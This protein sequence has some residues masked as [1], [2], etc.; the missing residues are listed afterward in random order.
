MDHLIPDYGLLLASGVLFVAYM[1]RGMVG[2]GSGLI[3]I[4]V[5][6]LAMPLTVAVPLVVILDVLASGAQGVRNR[7][8]IAWR[9]VGLILPF[10]LVGVGL[11]LSVFH[12]VDPLVLRRA[13]GAFVIAY[14]V[15]SL[16]SP[17][18]AQASRWWALP[19]GIGGGGI[20]T[21]FGTGG[22]FYVTY[23]KAR[24]LHKTAFRPT[25]ATLF[26][27]DASAR[28]AG[29]VGTGIIDVDLLQWLAMGVPVMIVAMYLGGHLH[30]QVGPS[31]FSRAISVLL[32]V[33]GISLMM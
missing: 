27:L 8:A 25:F 28:V 16:W 5:L 26:L 19:A 33:S 20:G 17:G 3:A 30:A 32:V 23:L 1:V 18:V 7:Q 29:Y 24:G 22:P 4:P 9:E 31:V 6:S 10:G 12:L 11:G 2:F 14:A 15:Y 21:V 13:M